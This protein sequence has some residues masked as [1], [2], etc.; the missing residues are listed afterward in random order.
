MSQQ[1]RTPPRKLKV[2]H[3]N[4]QSLSKKRNMLLRHAMT[5]R[6]DVILVQ[7]TKL[8]FAIKFPSYQVFQ[9]M[10]SGS[11]GGLLTLR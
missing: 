8:A 10:S 1:N 4:A 11:C 3:W 7:E 2:L 6:V 9:E 5:S